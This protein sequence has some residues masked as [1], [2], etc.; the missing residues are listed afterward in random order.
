M[1][2]VKATAKVQVIIEVDT[3]S[4][5]KDCTVNQILR[6]ASEE[7]VNKVRRMIETNNARIVGDPVV[8]A[9]IGKTTS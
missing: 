8:I 9:T 6:Q 3:S 2:I 7:A 5:G 1:E 4:W